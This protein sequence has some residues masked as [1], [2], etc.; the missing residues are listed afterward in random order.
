MRFGPFRF[1]RHNLL[2]PRR[3]RAKSQ[4]CPSSGELL[5]GK[6]V[7]VIDEKNRLIATCKNCTREI[8]VGKTAPIMTLGGTPC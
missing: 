3:R 1:P 5:Q 4:E 8:V 7:C 2:K 6:F